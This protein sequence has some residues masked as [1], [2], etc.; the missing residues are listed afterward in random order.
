MVVHQG[1]RAGMGSG[2]RGPWVQRG[3]A[4]PVQVQQGTGDPLRRFRPLNTS[5]HV[6]IKHKSGVYGTSILSSISCLAWSICCGDPRMINSLKLGSPLGGGWREIS[7]KAP[8]CWLMAFT[9][10]P[11]R[12]IT[13]PHL[14]AGIEKVISPP[15]G[16]Q[17]P[18]PRPLPR[19]PGG[20]PVPGGP[21]GP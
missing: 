17:L 16:P 4:H 11:P 12:P 20:M 15:G 6:K 9:F 13:R 8:V 1:V 21:G 7:T 14:W 2:C 19:P 3:P 10:S 5:E 18:G